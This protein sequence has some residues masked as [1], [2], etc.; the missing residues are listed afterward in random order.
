[1]LL[2]TLGANLLGN[3]L[4]GNKKVRAGKVIFRACKDT[5]REVEGAVSAVRIFNAASLFNQF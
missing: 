3:L 5:I 2:S 4:T 1:M